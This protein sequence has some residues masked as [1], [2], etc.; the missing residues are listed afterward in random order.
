MKKVSSLTSNFSLTEQKGKR[1]KNVCSLC[2]RE[3]SDRA[4]TTIFICS[5]C[6]DYFVRN[7]ERVKIVYDKLEDPFKKELLEKWLPK[8][9]I[10][11]EMRKFE[12]RIIVRS[13]KIN[14]DIRRKISRGT[15]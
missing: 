2:G 10:E 4:E 9:N 6:T 13:K 5:R 14:R 8:E 12:K 3:T 7:P 1:G 11:P 15:K